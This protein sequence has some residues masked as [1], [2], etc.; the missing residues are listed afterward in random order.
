[1]SDDTEE[2]TDHWGRHYAT[3]EDLCRAYNVPVAVF[4]PRKAKGLTLQQC[5]IKI[6]TQQKR[7]TKLRKIC[8]LQ[9]NPLPWENGKNTII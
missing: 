4:L 8:A 3:L 5:L 1:M 2:I 7:K 9:N 6:R